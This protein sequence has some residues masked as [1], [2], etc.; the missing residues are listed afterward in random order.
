[1]RFQV[2]YC[3]L[4]CHLICS[5]LS[6]IHSE[7]LKVAAKIKNVKFIFIFSIQKSGAKTSAT[8][9]HLPKLRFTHNFLKENKIQ[10]FRH[11]NACI[12]HINRNCNLRQ[13]FRVGKFINQ[14]LCI[15][16]LVVN[17]LCKTVQVWVFRIENLK[18]FFSVKVIF[19]KY[20]RLSKFFAV[21]NFDAI[22]HKN[23]KHLTDCITVKYPFIQSRRTNS[24]GDFS[25]F[26]LK[27]IFIFFFFFIS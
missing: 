18:Y 23:I 12:E 13:F 11:I 15:V 8:P 26:V 9:Y 14:T 19:S 3:S 17:H 10:N 4:K 27:Q 21:F 6:L 5:R 7:K 20:N 1:M 22:S 25:I 24:F 16:D 2:K